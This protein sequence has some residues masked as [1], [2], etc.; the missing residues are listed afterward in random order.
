M[1][2]SEFC[3]HRSTNQSSASVISS[4]A[5][6]KSR[7]ARRQK[8][9]G[10]IRAGRLATCISGVDLGLFVVWTD[11]V[12][13][14]ACSPGEEM[15]LVEHIKGMAL[16]S[17]AKNE[18]K[19][20]LVVLIQLSKEESARQLQVAADN[21]EVSQRAAVKLT[22]DTV[23]NDKVDENAHTLEHYIRI[24]RAHGSIHSETQTGS[25][26]IKALSPP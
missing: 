22:E 7:G 6:S 24:L 3:C 21:F 17:S 1:W 8:K 11:L 10:K 4:S 25:W 9:G 23:C 18:L 12:F 19:S 16:T 2:N 20:L 26:R 13:L 15:A 14:Y 5:A